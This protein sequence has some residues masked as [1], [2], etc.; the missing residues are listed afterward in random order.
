MLLQ[1][2][3]KKPHETPVLP[4]PFTGWFASNGWH[5]HTH[6]LAMIKAAKAGQSS[7]LIAPTGG[8]KTLA[9]FLPTLVSLVENPHKGLHTLYISPLKALAAD[10][11]RNLT[12]PITDMGL[13]I[14]I[15]MRTGDTSSSQRKRQLTKPPHILLITPE[16]LELMLSY[17]ESF[18]LFSTL[19]RVIIDE[20]HVLAPGKRGHLTALCLARLKT[21]SPT[22]TVTGLSATIAEPE[23]FLDWLDKNTCLIRATEAAAP[24]IKLLPTSVR[25]PWSGYTGLYAVRDIYKAIKA[26]K[27]TIIF[28]N[29]RVQAELFFQKLWEINEDNLPIALHHGSLEREHRQKVEALMAEGK[30]RAIVATAS[31]DLGIDWGAVDLVIQVGG[32][33][34]ISRLLQRIGRANHRLDTPS[35]AFLLANNRF[36]MAECIAVMQ[37]V[38]EGVVDGEPLTS[39][40]LD[41]L[42]QFV[43]NCTCARPFEPEHLWH[44]LRT[45][46]PYAKIPRTVFDKVVALITNGGYALRAYD[47]F[48]RITADEFGFYHAQ[49]TAIK[50]HRMNLGTIV[51][52]ETLRVSLRKPKS[53]KSRDLGQVE[54]YFIQGLLPGDTFMFAGQLLKFKA[55]RDMRVEVEPATGDRPKVP[56]FKGGRLPMSQSVADRVRRL[57]EHSEEEK[58][59][60]SISEWL[61]QQ[62]LRSCLPGK[63][64]LLAETF[65]HDGF[66]HFI[67]Y[68][69]AGRNANQTL[70]LLITQRLEAKGL[71]PLGFIANDYTIMFWGMRE[72]ID[73]QSLLEESL[74]QDNSQSWI[75]ASQMA[76]RAFRD[77][78]VISGLVERSHPG[79]K[80]TGRQVTMST[81]LLYDVLRKYEPDHILLQATRED[82]ELKL[83]DTVHLRD[84]MLSQPMKH[85]KLKRVSP[86]AVPLMIE[87]GS[88]II[89][90]EAQ[91]ALLSAEAR[92]AVGDA[93]FSEAS[94]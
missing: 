31:L 11:Q 38:D 80:K 59:P 25:V 58:L 88:E 36:E 7:L 6:Q 39:G 28:V 13:P 17:P 90:G 92:D 55:V 87:M 52:Y 10:I 18:T 89:K 81:D 46:A 64:F 71:L 51:E 54:E 41:V 84:I 47:R 57:M 77:I 78:A 14:T 42:A 34:S 75:E 35:K 50:R 72:I 67:L 63:D 53:K 8:G 74:S 4:Q 9:G 70:G 61:H 5:P 22:M 20:L 68:S 37:A 45:A 33:R 19:K 27:T 23:R 93:L 40:S 60:K 49:P 62:S 21:I 73:P 65:P 86:L 66:S 29:A 26:A 43:M 44:E 79:K 83:A 94:A 3:I 16:S 56:S 15:E 91:T 85:M 32:P 48:Q 30:L 69:F 2:R 12:T 1:E 76:R 82:V 24:E